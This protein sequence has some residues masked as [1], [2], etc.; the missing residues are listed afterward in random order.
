MLPPE[1]LMGMAESISE[2]FLSG[3]PWSST[4]LLLSFF[5]GQALSCEGHTDEADKEPP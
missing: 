2:H 5:L 4:K 1:K 3:N